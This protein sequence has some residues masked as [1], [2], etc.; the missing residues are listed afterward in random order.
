MEPVTAMVFGK[1]AEVFTEKFA[2]K[3]LSGVS[4]KLNPGD[5][6]KAI[7]IA[8]EKA[9]QQQPQLFSY[10]DTDFIGSFLNHF[11]QGQGL[12]ELQKPLQNENI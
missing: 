9:E 10:C 4:S 12:E 1:I 3:L 8:I 11:F 7:K 6:A 2:E 5:L